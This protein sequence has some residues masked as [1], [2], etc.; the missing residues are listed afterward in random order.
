MNLYSAA[1]S[2]VGCAVFMGY[3]R[4]DKLYRI[5]AR[6]EEF[7][8]RMAKKINNYYDARFGSMT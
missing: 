5:I 8:L 6:N 7:L 1:V 4:S 3:K 2:E